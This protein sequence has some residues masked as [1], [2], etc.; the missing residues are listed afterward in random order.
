MTTEMGATDP[1]VWGDPLQLQQVFLNIV[2]NAE[3]ALRDGG[4]ALEVTAE[5]AA[6]SSERDPGTDWISIAFF[7]DGP[8]IPPEVIPHIFEPLFTTKGEGEG[9]GL[10]LSIC[11]RIVREH[12]GDI[13][14]ESG[15][16]G[17]VFRIALPA[18]T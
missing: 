8:P 15:A 7:N 18:A 6:P 11:R 5:R 13:E 16:H 12:G 4:H 3:H 14:V 10:G 1:P 17:T 9:T 2:I